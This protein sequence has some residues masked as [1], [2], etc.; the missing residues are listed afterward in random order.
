MCMIGSV[1]HRKKKNLCRTNIHD[2][3]LFEGFFGVERYV[4]CTE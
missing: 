1:V 4:T 2:R 3:K